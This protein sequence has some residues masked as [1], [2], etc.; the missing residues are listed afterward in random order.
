MSMMTGSRA[1]RRHRADARAG[2][3]AVRLHVLLRRDDDGRG[4]VDEAA[5][6]AGS[7]HVLD[8]LGLRVAKQRDLIERLA[9]GPDG[10]GAHAR[11]TR[12]R[13]APSPSSVVSARGF[14]SWASAILPVAGSTTANSDFAKR[15]SSI[16]RRGVLLRQEREGVD[17]RRA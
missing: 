14:S 16:A 7:V 4:A 12:P 6:V 17:A 11:R 15:F 2:L 10:G 5:R 1:D 9:V 8:R 3:Q 13:A